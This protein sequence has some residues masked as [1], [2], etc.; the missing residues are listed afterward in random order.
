MP[1]PLLRRF[2][3][4][5]TLALVAAG[6]SACDGGGTTT[7]TTPTTPTTTV[8]ETFAGSIT[9][10]GAASFTFPTGAAGSVTATLRTITPVSTIQLSL[11]LGTWNGISCQVVL[12]NDRAT[13]GGSVTGNVSGSGTLCVRIADIGQVAGTSGFEIVV[14][15]P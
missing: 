9:T 12:T 7:P 11:A 14:V 6:A 3:L 5:S 13:S 4:I 15:H 10:N 2:A 8:T 1:S